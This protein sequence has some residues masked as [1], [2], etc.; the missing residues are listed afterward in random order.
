MLFWAAYRIT[1]FA[2][3]TRFAQ[4][5]MIHG[6]SHG[7]TCPELHAC[8]S[9]YL[10]SWHACMHA[11][12]SRHTVRVHTWQPEYVPS[13]FLQRKPASAPSKPNQLRSTEIAYRN[14]YILRSEIRQKETFQILRS[15]SGE[16]EGPI[17]ATLPALI[18]W[19]TN[20]RLLAPPLS[21]SDCL[22]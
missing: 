17:D 16:W 4:Q 21:G 6:L 1:R 13:S 14:R 9:C 15:V 8:A 3:R 20:G 12:T 18:V 22:K 19:Y 11:C 10:Q 2:R 7:I 5:Y